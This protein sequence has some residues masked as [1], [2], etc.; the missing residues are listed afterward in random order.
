MKFFKII[1][2]L[3]LSGVL[4]YIPQDGVAHKKEDPLKVKYHKRLAKRYKKRIAQQDLEINKHIKMIEDYQKHHFIKKDVNSYPK[5]VENLT[6]HC[7]AI[8]RAAKDLRR[9]YE[10]M[11]KWHELKIEDHGNK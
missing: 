9:E 5:D 1:F 8:I 3:M 7:E 2:I 10:S 6:K 4:V 11:A